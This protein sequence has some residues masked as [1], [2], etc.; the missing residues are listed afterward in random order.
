[1][2]DKNAHFRPVVA[3]MDSI[4]TS[5]S[6][7]NQSTI[8]RRCTQSQLQL[9]KLT[10]IFLIALILTVVF[11]I[12]ALTRPDRFSWAAPKSGL[13]RIWVCETC[14]KVKC[15]N[16]ASLQPIGAGFP[17]VIFECQNNLWNPPEVRHQNVYQNA[18]KTHEKIIEKPSKSKRHSVSSLGVFH[19]T[20]AIIRVDEAPWVQVWWDTSQGLPPGQSCSSAPLL[21]SVCWEHRR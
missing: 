10:T 4:R 17:K 12:A 16:V 13:K 6:N 21:H 20:G 7:A 9:W 3:F 14:K 2:I 15:V 11:T 5:S 1:M 19:A 18:L 8:D